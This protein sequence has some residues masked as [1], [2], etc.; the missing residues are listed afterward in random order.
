MLRR[1]ALVLLLCLCAT[2]YHG[3]GRL[4]AADSSATLLRGATVVVGN[5]Q[6]LSGASVLVRDGLIEAVG[7]AVQAPA[8]AIEVD[9][10][11]AFLYPG[12]IDALTDQGLRKPHLCHRRHRAHRRPGVFHART[13][14]GA[15]AL[16]RGRA[17]AADGVGCTRRDI[18]GKR[19]RPCRGESD[20]E[21]GDPCSVGDF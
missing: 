21:G 17:P 18:R 10:K 9:L 20:G 3:A 15:A 13:R 7:P 14:P 1:V 2:G 4:S 8:G 6:V 16:A 19:H 11:G 12:L 5:G